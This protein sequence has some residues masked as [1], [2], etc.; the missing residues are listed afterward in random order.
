MT[1]PERAW[2]AGEEFSEESTWWVLK[3]DTSATY[4][5]KVRPFWGLNALQD[6][7]LCQQ[8]A[9]K[10][11]LVVRDHLLTQEA[12]DWDPALCGEDALEEKLAAHASL[13]ACR[14][15]RTE[16]PGGLQ[17]AGSQRVRHDWA[18]K[19]QQIIIPTLPVCGLKTRY[20]VKP[21]RFQ[22]SLCQPLLGHLNFWAWALF[23]VGFTTELRRRYRDFPHTLPHT[24]SASRTINIIHQNGAFC[25]KDEPALTPYNHPRP[26][27]YI[28][29]HAWWLHSIG[30]RTSTTT[31][32]H[33]YSHTE[34]GLSTKRPRGLV[35]SSPPP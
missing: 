34:S 32:T 33:P 28:S 1:V 21:A 11:A 12:W 7:R 16:E 23:P 25:T 27:A 4:A 13:L 24:R 18:T 15:P 3:T 30:M 31:Y 10:V 22:F 26:I 20:G 17:S 8:R 9:S 2:G 35:Y 6:S 19:Q 29:V 5:L 14:T